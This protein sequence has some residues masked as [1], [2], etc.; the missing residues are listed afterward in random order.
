MAGK[1]KDSKKG[2][3][4]KREKNNQCP[5]K[6]GDNCKVPGVFSDSEPIGGGG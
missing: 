6:D 5:V 2:Q 4:V 1:E 3:A